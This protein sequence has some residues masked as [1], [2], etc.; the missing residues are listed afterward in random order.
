MKVIIPSCVLP[1]KCYMYKKFAKYYDSLYKWKDYKSESET[2]RALIKKYKSSRGKDMLDAACGT[3]NH[4]QYLRKH[5]NITGID[6]DKDMLSIARKKLSGIRFI[7]GDMRTFKLYKQFDVIVCLF[8]AIGHLKTYANLEKTIKNFSFHLK[9]G[10]VMIIE[11]FVDPKLYIEGRI[12]AF[13]VNEPDLI[14]TRMNKSERKGNIAIFNFHFLVGEKGKIKY[15]TDRIKLGMFESRKVVAF[16]KSIGLISKYLKDGL[17][18]DRGL[19][20][21]IKP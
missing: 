10:G 20:I 7:N 6:I 17:M 13:N 8:S 11:P 18:K 12:H 5:F 19:Y 1:G 15:F 21:G 4:I 3:G 16:M 14:L 2:L 9:P